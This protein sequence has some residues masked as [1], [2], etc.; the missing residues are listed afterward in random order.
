[1]DKVDFL[2]NPGAWVR[3]LKDGTIPRPVFTDEDRAYLEARRNSPAGLR[4]RMRILKGKL[5]GYHEDRNRFERRAAAA[6]R[7]NDAEGFALWREHCKYS[8]DKII[9][10]NEKLCALRRQEKEARAQARA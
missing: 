3:G 2:S 4:D 5:G 6:L 9:K 7:K 8:T 1:M 10:A